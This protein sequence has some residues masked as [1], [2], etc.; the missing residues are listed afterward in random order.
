VV[1]LGLG[2][3]DASMIIFEDEVSFVTLMLYPHKNRHTMDNMYRCKGTL[4]CI[5][6]TFLFV[7]DFAN[8]G[9][10][11]LFKCNRRDIL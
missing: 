11:I 1:G 6:R 2:R 8:K 10:V 9:S 7:G 4:F 5:F 3:E